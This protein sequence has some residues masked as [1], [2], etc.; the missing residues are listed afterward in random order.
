MISR[1]LPINEQ[2]FHLCCLI[3]KLFLNHVVIFLTFL[4]LSSF[5][6]NLEPIGASQLFDIYKKGDFRYII[7]SLSGKNDE[8]ILVKAR[9]AFAVGDRKLTISLLSQLD[10]KHL[11]AASLYYSCGEYIKAGEIASTYIVNS[12]FSGW[13]A[14]YLKAISSAALGANTYEIWQDL[15][16]S[17]VGIFSAK[18]R[19]ELARFNFQWGYQDSMIYYLESVEPVLLEKRDRISYY[20]LKGMISY[21]AGNYQG[22]L[23]QFKKA[24]RIKYL[25]DGKKE[26]IA[27]SA[28]SLYPHLDKKNAFLLLDVFRENRYYDELINLLKDSAVDDLAKMILAWCYFGKKEYS[29][30]S[31]IFKELSISEDED[32]KAEAIYGLAVCDYRRGWR[33]KA[34][35]KLLVFARNF[36]DSPLVPKALFTAGD[37]YQKSDPNRSIEIFEKLTT[38]Y[39]HSKYYPRALFLLGQLYARH[40]HRQESI[41]AF[42]SYENDD[43]FADL[44]DFWAFKTGLVDSTGLNRLIERKNPTLYNIK[45]RKI[46]GLVEKDTASDFDLFIE[47]FFNQ[48][49]K[50]LSGRTDRGNIENK[51]V[52]YIDS[53]YYYGLEREANRQVLYIHNRHH[54]LKTDILLLRKCEELSLDM[55][56]FKI[57]EDFKMALQKSGFSFSHDGWLRLNYPI[58]F[59]RRL[60][61]LA[62][63]ID[64]YLALAV[65]RRESRFEPKVVSKSGALGLMQLMPATASQMAKVEKIDPEMLFDPGYNI[66]LGCRYI[67]WLDVRLRRDEVVI[68][69]YNAGPTAARRWKRQAGTD[70][71]TFIE[72]IDY[73]QS[74]NYTRGVIGDY[75]WYKYLWPNQFDDN[76]KA[77]SK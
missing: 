27:F 46:L 72:A 14:I 19:L 76:D 47:A 54:S 23:R 71:E 52:A 69:A 48:V 73:E 70:I 58:L 25:Y 64:P 39:P 21:K 61:W 8:E 60:S 51:Q 57:L 38:I 1:K 63:D 35:E 5:V 9:T 32:L 62:E 20:Y 42:S 33:V 12:A 55:A 37:F 13:L 11:Q 15:V 3:Q 56:F 74:R 59:E 53:L 75:L 44:F 17:P 36:P 34:V 28:D 77:T 22:A 10:E 66:K 30:A 50:F 45:A 16:D 7:D 67:R 65:I 49:E 18:A 43:E 24:L 31:R 2:R 41:K 40:G 29:T 4:L 68:A 26:V 6:I